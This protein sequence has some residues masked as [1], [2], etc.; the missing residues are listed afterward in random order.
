M[1]DRD[2]DPVADAFRGSRAYQ[3]SRETIDRSAVA[4]GESTSLNRWRA[5]QRAFASLPVKRKIEYVATAIAIASIAHLAIRELLPAYA[6]S[7]LPWW[8][9]V[10]A[11][12]GAVIVAMLAGPISSASADSAP[13]KLWR[14]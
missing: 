4:A 10:S 12:V 2:F 5:F 14:R 3:V 13:A 8:W 7:G 6:T 1:R 9:N 11:A